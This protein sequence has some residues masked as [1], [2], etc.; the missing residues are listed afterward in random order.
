MEVPLKKFLSLIVL[1][2]LLIA[3]PVLAADA[4]PAASF[5]DKVL[6]VL[7]D[8]DKYVDLLNSLLVAIIAIA[9]VIPGDQ[10]EK[11]LKQVVDFISKFSKKPKV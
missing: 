9:L 5:L 2:V 10:P 1:A 4:A 6:A 8:L 3:F 7:K 11:F